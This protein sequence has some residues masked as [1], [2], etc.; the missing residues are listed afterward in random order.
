[1]KL[2]IGETGMSAV[3]FALVAPIF[4]LF[5][6]GIVSF[7]IYFGVDNCVQELAAEAV[8]A[9]APGISPTQRDQL[10][11]NYVIQNLH[12][13][14]LL[15]PSDVSV[16]TSSSGSAYQVS[17]SYDLSASPIFGFRLISMPSPVIERTAATENGGF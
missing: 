1:M 17:V 7:G 11:R 4:L 5:L 12:A 2:S 8:R 3:E 15:I 9:S 16:T 14:P 10:A 13:Y 6:L